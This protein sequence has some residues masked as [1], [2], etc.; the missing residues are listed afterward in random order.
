MRQRRASSLIGKCP[1]S[2]ARVF[3]TVRRWDIHLSRF[4]VETSHA[5]ACKPG[6]PHGSDNAGHDP[7]ARIR[8]GASGALRY[9]M[10]SEGI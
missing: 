4:D 7:L 5:E 2:S 10:E 9:K 8:G 1:H 6:R 3:A